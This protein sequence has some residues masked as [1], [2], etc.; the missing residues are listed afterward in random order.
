MSWQTYVDEHL[1]CDIDGHHLASAAIIGQ[2]GSIW[3]QS[4]GFPQVLSL[5][6]SFLCPLYH[7][8]LIWWGPVSLISSVTSDV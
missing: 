4:S 3:A 8:S 6:F 5:S 7:L 2:D 1:M